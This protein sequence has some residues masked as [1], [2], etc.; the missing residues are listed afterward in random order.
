MHQTTD[1][2]P[3]TSTTPGLPSH[4]AIIM[5]GNGRW[6]SG[7]GLGRSDGHKEG[8]RAVRRVVTRSRELGLSHLTLYA[9]SAQNWGRPHTE[10][11]Q[12]MALL[13]EFCEQERQLLLDKDIRFRVIGERTRLPAYAR[14]AAEL[15]EAATEHATSMQLLIALS[16]GGREEIAHACRALAQEVQRGEISPDEIDEAA[17]TRHLW[18]WDVPDPDLVIRTSGELRVSNFL[19]WQIAY[20]EFHIDRVCWPDFDEA[21][22]DRAL[23]AYLDRDRRFGGLGAS[24]ESSE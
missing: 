14:Q 21:A 16:Y 9:F 20:S 8:A 13:V 12:L 5:D 19:L 23:R 10:V 17:I 1:I 3:I 15:L 11:E 2:L 6:A 24:D 4:V 22:F 18:T 7:R